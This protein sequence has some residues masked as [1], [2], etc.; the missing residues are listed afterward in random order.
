MESVREINGQRSVERRYYLSSLSA[1]IDRF[2]KAVRGHWSIENQLHWVLDVV[3]GE[4]QARA[5]TKQAAENL[6]AMRRLAVNLL[7]RDKLCKRSIKGKLMRA[8]IDPDYLRHRR[9]T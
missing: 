3:F 6:A 9:L 7:R 1:D 2:A 4:D 5:R 8:A